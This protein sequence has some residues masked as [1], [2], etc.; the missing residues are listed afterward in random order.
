MKKILHTPTRR[1]KKKR[2]PRKEKKKKKKTTICLL[3]SA[4]HSFLHREPVYLFISSFFI[5]LSLSLFLSYTPLV[6]DLSAS[7][8]FLL[9]LH[10][11]FFLDL[12]LHSKKRVDFLVSFHFFF[13]F[14]LYFVIIFFFFIVR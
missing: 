7:L 2:T 1:G 11:C 5:F 10:F 13:F 6:E 8:H 3:V 9:L 14:F 4:F 12:V